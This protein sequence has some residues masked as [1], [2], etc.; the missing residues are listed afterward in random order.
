MPGHDYQIIAPFVGT[1][2]VRVTDQCGTDPPTSFTEAAGAAAIQSGDPINNGPTALIQHS[3]D[4][5]TFSGSAS[6]APSPG[7]SSNW[8]WS[9]TG[10]T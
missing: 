5:H 7:E 9:A 8:S 6:A 3:P 4:G 10:S 1:E 2:D